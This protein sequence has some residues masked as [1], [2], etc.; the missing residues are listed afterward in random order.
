[1]PMKMPRPASESTRRFDK[2]VG[3]DERIHVRKV[4]GNPAAFVNGN[5]C[6]GVFGSDVFLRFSEGDQELARKIP[7][8]RPFEPMAGRPMRG[9]LIL[10]PAVLEN[11][12]E[13]RRWVE[14][15][16]QH[17]LRLPPKPLKARAAGPRRRA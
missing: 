16:I 12:Q 8:A 1:M 4:F 9:Y 6:F 3:G 15:A 17:T 5:M 14:A 13:S 7:G 11:S 2:L 10:P